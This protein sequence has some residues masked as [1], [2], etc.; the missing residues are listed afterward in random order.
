ME[1]AH[2]AGFELKPG[3][4]RLEVLEAPHRQPSSLPSGLMALYGF[5][6]PDGWLK[7]GIAG[8][9]SQAR[10]T[11][12]HYNA[13]SAPSTLAASLVKDPS[14]STCAGFCVD[15]PGEWIRSNCH[16]V[17]VLIDAEHGRPLLALL[18]AFLHVRLK[19]RYER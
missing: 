14:M 4:L 12:Q 3:E 11:S 18:E 8:K 1:V 15:S 6:G 19:P 5:C 7:I 10:Y 16:R 9:Q 13:R 17:N 2:L